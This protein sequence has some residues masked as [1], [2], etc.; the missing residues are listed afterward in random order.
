[1]HQRKADSDHNTILPGGGLRDAFLNMRNEEAHPVRESIDQFAL[2]C[3]K[4][5]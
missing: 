1:M 2:L 4:C 5:P 3:H